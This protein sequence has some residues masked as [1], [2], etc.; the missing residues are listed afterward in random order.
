M[1]GFIRSAATAF[2]LFIAGAASAAAADPPARVGR[3]S[4]IEGDVTFH[5]TA[6]REAAPAVLNWP[7]TGG[8]AFSTAPGARAEVRIGSTA[9]RLDGATALE[10]VQ[11]DDRSIRL[12]LEHGAVALRVRN[13]EVAGELVLETRDARA[14]F[15]EPGR[16][17]VEAGRTPDT[18][19]VTAFDGSA[20]VEADGMV[21]AVRPGRRVEVG[22]GGLGRVVEAF[23]DGFDAWTL[24][25]DRRDDAVREAPRYVSPET[26]GY[27]SLDEHGDWRQVPDYGPVWYPRAVPAGWAP[28]RTG[29][30]AWIEPWGWT[31][32]DEA[33]WGFAPFHYGRWALIGGFWGWVPGAFVARPVYAPALVGWVG[34]PGWSVGISIGSVPAVGWFPLAPR[35]VFVPAYRCST[36]YVRNV[37]VTHV[38]NVVNITSVPPRRYEHRHVER[39]VTV[40]PAVAVAGGQPVGRAAVHVRR[41]DLVADAGASSGPPANAGRPPR[42]FGA[43]RRDDGDRWTR[44]AQPVTAAPAQSTPQPQAD[45]RPDAGR[46]AQREP[47]R[48]RD[49][50]ERG[51]E[52]RVERA[53]P[54]PTQQAAPAATPSA[55][56]RS[57]PTQ[58]AP[59]VTRPTPPVAAERAQPRGE[60]ERRPEQRAERE[61]Q[62]PPR[63][64]P[65]VVAPTPRATADRDPRRAEPFRRPEQRVE[66]QRPTTTPA[67]PVVTAPSGQPRATAPQAPR[68][69]FERREDPRPAPRASAPV[70][71]PA[72]V[73]RAPAPMQPS[74]PQVRTPAPPQPI[75][76]AQ[77]VPRPD[78]NR[79]QPREARQGE[80]RGG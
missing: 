13:P 19:A 30:W 32:V 15:A 62:T 37:N 72:A 4:L 42:Q 31:W 16:Y 35:E 52:Q 18:T 40:V 12:R 78:T 48:R 59:A 76:P 29:R 50:A 11:V 6:E 55:P 14:S 75:G 67:A 23:A 34:R 44:R 7:V 77:P 49:D 27:E 3:L 45:R 66:P 58:A 56:P 1:R 60:P 2:I 79:G 61:R 41:P 54:A 71:P 36:V 69:R 5:D 73:M 10:F 57:A 68:E 64:A 9:I 25:L 20:Q 8:A 38:T 24:A 28:Y 63:A 47:E 39:A 46:Q 17:R 80:R 65:P 51:P 53:R 26:T 21:I 43:P 33:P 74:A 70:P 22:L